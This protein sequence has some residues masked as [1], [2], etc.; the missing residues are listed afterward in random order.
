MIVSIQ[1][2]ND[3]SQNYEDSV[4]ALNIKTMCLES[5]EHLVADY[6]RFEPSEVYGENV[7]SV[8]RLTVL[9]LATLMLMEAGENIGVSSK[10]MP[11]NSRTFISYTNYNKY[12]QPL[13]NLRKVV[14]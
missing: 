7:P 1:S 10:S 12:L 3:Y 9:R 14:F 6:L 13:Q 11:D 8:I 4:N 5:A 2:F